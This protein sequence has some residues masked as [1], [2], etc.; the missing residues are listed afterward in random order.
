MK[1][2]CL[3]SLLLL[4]AC[5]TTQTVKVPVPVECKTPTPAA[6]E[7]GFEK[8]SKNDDLYVKVRA[9]LADR[10]LSKAYETELLAALLSCK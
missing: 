7:F 4:S 1:A 10:E 5:A 2:A 6:P 8:L 9:L 3:L